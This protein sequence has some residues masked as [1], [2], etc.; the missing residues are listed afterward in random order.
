[1]TLDWD[2]LVRN[3]GIEKK[4]CIEEEVEGVEGSESIGSMVIW[5]VKMG[6]ST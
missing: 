6:L 4:N 1:M 3:V 5:V 2:F